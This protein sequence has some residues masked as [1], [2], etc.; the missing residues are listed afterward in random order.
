MGAG[1]GGPPA[2]LGL[3]GGP[4]RRASALSAPF[5]AAAP[6]PVVH[7]VQCH[8]VARR[9]LSRRR[10]S[11]ARAPRPTANQ[12]RCAPSLLFLFDFPCAVLTLGFELSDYMAA[13]CVRSRSQ[14]LLTEVVLPFSLF[15]CGRHR[16]ERAGGRADHRAAGGAAE[17]GQRPVTLPTPVRATPRVRGAVLRRGASRC[18]RRRGGGGS[19]QKNE[20]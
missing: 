12:R 17:P 20:T 10:R 13:S 8:V 19:Y 16:R 14:R 9:L 11:V 18:V 1:R 2:G 6:P 4:A 5:A 15:L 7:D 3:R